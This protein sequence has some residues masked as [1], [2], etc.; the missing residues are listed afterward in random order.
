MDSSHN[1]RID[2][3]R[4]SYREAH[5]RFV[6]RVSGAGALA[7][8][9]PPDGGWSVAQ[10]AWHVATVDSTFAAIIA[11]ERPSLVLPADFHERSWREIAAGIPNRLEAAA[12][13]V[14]PESM[15][16]ADALAALDRAAARIGAALDVLTPDRG[17]RQGITHEIVG[18]ISLYQVGEWAVAHTI[19]HNAH[20]KR[21]LSS[22][23]P[24]PSAGV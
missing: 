16:A 6:A 23:A 24:S 7:E 15:S 22:L 17:S 14:P 5:A 2:H 21:V 4:D 8:R 20:A 3:V 11:G 9:V 13:S 12:P 1:D 10:I 19:R 18:T